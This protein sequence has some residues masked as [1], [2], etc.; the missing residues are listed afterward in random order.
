MEYQLSVPCLEYFIVQ[1][2]KAA[3]ALKAYFMESLDY[4]VLAREGEQT[5]SGGHNRIDYKISIS[6]LGY[7][8]A[9]RITQGKH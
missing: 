3:R 9:G 8:I 6:C 2:D 5:G 4:Q 7:F 1:D